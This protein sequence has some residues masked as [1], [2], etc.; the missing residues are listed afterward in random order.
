VLKAPSIVLSDD[1][2]SAEQGVKKDSRI[3]RLVLVEPALVI[4]EEKQLTFRVKA[5]AS[6]VAVG[7]VVKADILKHGY[8]FQ[9]K[10][11]GH[12]CYMLSNNGYCWSSY[13][14]HQNG[15]NV[16]CPFE[17]EDVVRVAFRGSQVVFSLPRQGLSHALDLDPACL[18]EGGLHFAANLMAKGDQVSI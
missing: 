18:K 14:S 3:E 7:I 4:G 13:Q 2:L 8:Q 15:A 10:G 9:S 16:K 5:I 6:W 17:K 11:L 1:F 12:G